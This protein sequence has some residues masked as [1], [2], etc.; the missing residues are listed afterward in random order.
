MRTFFGY[1]SIRTVYANSVHNRNIFSAEEGQHEDLWGW[2]PSTSHGAQY[3]LFSF[4][5][6][7]LYHRDSGAHAPVM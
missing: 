1:T 2:H 5:D 3:C 4:F 7:F 6:L